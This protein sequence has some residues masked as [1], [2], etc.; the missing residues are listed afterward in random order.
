MKPLYKWA[1]GKNK[2][3]NNH[4]LKY[5]PKSFNSYCEPF[6]GGGAMFIW[7]YNK[8]K[9]ASFTINDINKDIMNIYRSIKNDYLN[10][11]KDLDSLEKRYLCLKSPKEI[12]KN[13]DLEKKH[14]IGNNRKDWKAIYNS[15]PSRRHF[16]FMMRDEY[17]FNYQNLTLTEESALLYFLMQTSFNGVW[18][19]NANT[20]GRFGTPCGLLKEKTSIYDKENLKLWNIA[21]QNTDIRDGD[22]S[23]CHDVI[24]HDTYLFMDPPYRGCFTNYGTQD[25]DGFQESVVNFFLESKS[26]GAYCML[27]NREL[28]DGFF[29]VRC[30][31]DNIVN[32]DITY[33]AGRRKKIIDQSGNESFEAKKAIEILIY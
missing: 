17:A 23:K 21:L 14:K 6:F 32:F 4:Y 19:V 33:T 31:N 30:P 29:E 24:N 8:N 26:K 7:A 28:G 13:K 9:N 22:F 25:D 27:S 3:I 18:Q 16:Y 12:N 1:G 10:F 20:N 2:L 5:L 15:E 11:V